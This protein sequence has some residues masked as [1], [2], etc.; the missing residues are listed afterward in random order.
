MKIKVCGMRE[1]ENI[2]QLV[3][4]CPDFIG[5]IFYPK[6]KR[7]IGEQ[8]DRK[9]LSLIPP[10]IKKVGVVVD[11][12][13]KVLISLIKNNHLE[14]L[15]LHGNESPA[16]CLQLKTLGIRTIKAFSMDEQ[17]DFSFCKSY[18]GTC[19]YFL[20]DTKCDTKG[21]SGKKFNWNMLEKYTF[22]QPFFLSGGIGE[23]DINEILKLKEK[24][25]IFA[26]DINSRF[27]IEP[28][29]K[30]INS[31]SRFINTIRNHKTL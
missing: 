21:G 17:F 18:M 28:A 25:N 14:Y 1:P 22:N 11:E 31:I 7:Y 4:L 16:L 2:R 26:V 13:F 19:D 3:N 20:F 6:S 27:E 5:F 12:P 29:L 24:K 23:E 9:V 30:N 8:I 15:Q 10:S